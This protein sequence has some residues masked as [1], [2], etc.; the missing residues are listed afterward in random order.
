MLVDGPPDHG[1]LSRNLYF[2]FREQMIRLAELRTRERDRHWRI[3][4]YAGRKK[5]MIV[6]ILVRKFSL[7]NKVTSI[8]FFETIGNSF[9]FWALSQELMTSVTR[10]WHRNVRLK[11]MMAQKPAS[12]WFSTHC[13]FGASGER[14][15]TQ[16]FVKD[17]TNWVLYTLHWHIITC[18]HSEQTD[19]GRVW[20]M[21]NI[22]MD[23]WWPGDHRDNTQDV[24]RQSQHQQ[25]GEASTPGLKVVE[26]NKKTEAM[27]LS[28]IN[29]V[30][31]Q[32]YGFIHLTQ[33]KLSQLTC[34]T[35][36]DTEWLN[37]PCNPD[38]SLDLLSGPGCSLWIWQVAFFTV[39]FH[40]FLIHKQL[41]EN[42]AMNNNPGL[43]WMSISCNFS[44]SLSAFF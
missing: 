35:Q 26:G 21:I 10:Q 32:F 8:Y 44:S 5:Q 33:H 6:H 23:H 29:S 19:G 25:R 1:A 15:T 17:L 24:T 20:G 12:L 9:P 4:D 41:D 37:S 38:S 31:S 22:N 13:F 14:V 16:D 39:G 2:V 18:S 27:E 3:M 28:T 42:H 7:H 43:V 34:S 40:G 36:H 30:F 11:T